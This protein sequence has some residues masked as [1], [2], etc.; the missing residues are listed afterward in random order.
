MRILFLT[1]Y[2]PPEIGA[3]QNR[4]HELA[5]RLKAN[6]IDVEVL[7]AMPN[8]PKMEIFDAYKDGKIREEEIDGVKVFRSSIYVSHSKSIVS[9][10]LNY[11]SFVWTSYWRGRKLGN[12]DYLMVESPPLFLGYSAMRL[13]RKLKAKLIFNVSDLWPESAEKL[14]IVSNK[15]LLNLAYRLEKKCYQRSHL[16]TGQT[17]G[18]VSDISSR[19]TSKRVYWLPNGVDV[20]FYDSAKYEAIGFREKYGFHKDDIVFFYGGILGYAQG[21]Q[22]VVRAAKLASKNERIQI[23]LQ[24]AGPEKEMLLALKEELNVSN[25]HFLPPVPKNEMPH[26]LREVDVALVPLRKLELFLGAIPS[27]IF[28]ALSM[29]KALL[30]GVGGEAKSHFIEKAN[31]GVYF[32]PENESD[33][34]EKMIEMA[35]Q[36]EMIKSMG[37]N[38]RNYVKKNF[39]RNKIAEDLISELQK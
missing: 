4:L 16:I 30:L 28:E 11:F 12:Y 10:L 1:Q 15:Q 29:E 39:N 20:D 7:T 38:G 37:Q 25:L 35:L 5:V 22:T 21:L 3:P 18:I 14:G 31:A 33:L 6:G 23:V 9:R 13:S 32:E 2:Y 24:G 26:I 36:P 27:K 34:A 19:F 17:M 8:Y